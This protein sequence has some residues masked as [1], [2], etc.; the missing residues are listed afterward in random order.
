MNSR[1]Q[2]AVSKILAYQI[3]VSLFISA[4]FAL[5][6]GHDYAISSLLGGGAAFIPNLFFALILFKSS[7][8]S[9]RNVLNSLYIGELGKL[10][11]TGLL[12]VIIFN[13]PNIEVLPLLVGYITALSVFWFALLMR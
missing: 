1:K 8:R 10:L 11:L 9:A 13:T 7:G 2:S 4:G 3:L 12:F 5:Y 6:K